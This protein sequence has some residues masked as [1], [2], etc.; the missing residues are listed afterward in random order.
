M[1]GPG[2]VDADGCDEVVAGAPC[3]PTAHYLGEGYAALYSGSAGGIP[4]L[5][6]WWGRGAP[7][8]RSCHGTSVAGAGDVDGDG[9]VEVLVGAPEWSGPL[10]TEGRAAR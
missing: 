10:G 1:A 8:G 4:A 2:D 9:K 5:P 7:D 3:T 6:S